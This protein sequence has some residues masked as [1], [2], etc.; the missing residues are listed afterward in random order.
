MRF[1]LGIL[2]SREQLLP[3]GLLVSGYKGKDK[4]LYDNDFGAK[5]D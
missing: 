4:L 1:D 3:F 2:D 5:L